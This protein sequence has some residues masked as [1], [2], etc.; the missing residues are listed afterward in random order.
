MIIPARD[1][2]ALAAAMTRIA[3]DTAL[4]QRLGPA[5]RAYITEHYAADRTVRD[6]HEAYLKILNR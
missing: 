2:E 5:G 4:R 6:L 1:D 3:E